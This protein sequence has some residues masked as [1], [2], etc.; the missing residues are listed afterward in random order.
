[1]RYAIQ[2]GRGGQLVIAVRL[3]IAIA[4]V[5]TIHSPIGLNVNN[6]R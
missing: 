6:P 1:M 5:C 4:V 3:R 2:F